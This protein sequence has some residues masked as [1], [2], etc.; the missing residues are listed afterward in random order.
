[1]PTNKYPITITPPI[2][3]TILE[4]E[5]KYD[6]VISGIPDADR[7]VNIIVVYGTA[8]ELIPYSYVAGGDNFLHIVNITQGTVLVIF[9]DPAGLWIESFY[10]DNAKLYPYERSKFAP[11]IP[12]Y[13]PLHNFLD[14][15][16]APATTI[17]LTDDRNYN[18]PFTTAELNLYERS[19]LDL[20][21]QPAYDGSINMIWTDDSN[22]MRIVNSRFAVDESGTIAELIDRRARKDANTYNNTNFHQTELI[23]KAVTIPTLTF[24]G[25]VPGGKLPGGGYRYFFKYV[26]ADGAETDI[27]EE[28]RLVSVHEGATTLTAMGSSTLTTN[29]SV[30]FTLTDLDQSFYGVVVYYTY[31]SGDVDSVAV[32][33]RIASPYIIENTG[34][35]TII[36]SG[37]ETQALEDISKL[38]LTYSIISRA[39][40]LDVVNN[41]LLVG[42]TDA[43]DIYDP[44][45][46][47]A[48]ASLLIEEDTF[49]IEQAAALDESLSTEAEN[50]YS[51]PLF[52]YNSL[53]YWKG[54]TYELGIV[55]VTAQGLSP[56]YTLQGIDN[57]AGGVAYDT[58]LIG[59]L[60]R[61]YAA[62]GQNSAGIYRT[63]QRTDLWTYDAGLSKLTFSGTNLSVDV[64]PL[65]TQDLADK[66]TGFFFVRRKRKSDVILQGLMVPVAAVPIE[67]RFGSEYEIT[68]FGNWAGVG[69]KSSV[70]K[71]NVKFIPAP[72]G[73]MPFGVEETSGGNTTYIPWMTP[74]GEQVTAIGGGPAAAQ[75]LTFVEGI[76]KDDVIR[77][78]SAGVAVPGT[79]LSVTSATSTVTFTAPITVAAGAQVMIARGG[80]SGIST[81]FY[82]R[83]PIKD[84]TDINSWAL[85]STDVECA[86]AYYA[87]ILSGTKVGLE[88]FKQ[89]FTTTQI[90]TT[91]PSA[92]L[93][94]NSSLYNKITQGLQPVVSA[95]G[96]IKSVTA[97]YVDTGAIG[98]SALG[99]SGSTDR[100][101]G[102]FMDW[103][104]GDS[105]LTKAYLVAKIQAASD[106]FSGTRAMGLS[107][108]SRPGNALAFGRYIGIKATE[109]LASSL[110][111]LTITP[112]PA[113]GDENI[114]AYISLNNLGQ[115]D[116][117]GVS[118]QLGYVSAL[119]PTST[120]SPIPL[121]AWE[122]RYAVDE[123]TEY[124][125]IT[126]RFRYSDFFDATGTPIAPTT[127]EIY[128]GDCFLGMSWK[129]VWHPL[130]IIEAPQTSDIT[131]Y[132]A[133]RRSLGLLPYGHAIPIPAQSNYNFNV[134]SKERVDEVE[135]K[136]YGTDRSYLPIRGINSIRGNRQFETG[137]YNHGYDSE[138]VSA[139]KQ[140]RLNL[141]APFYR[142]RYPNRIYVS[143]ES[144]ENEFV[145]GFS[146][147]KGLNFR[148][149]NSNLGAI[150]K[151]IALNNVLIVVFKDGVA[152]VGVDERSQVS[153]D[154]GG[155]FVDSA[156]ILSRSDVVNSDYGSDHLHSICAS[157]NFVY[158]VDF[159]RYKVWRTNGAAMELISD[160]KIRNKLG[161]ISETLLDIFSQNSTDRWVDVFSNF[162]SRKN[163]IYFTFIVRDPDNNILHNLTRT[164]VF[165]ETLQCWICETNDV[166]KFIFQSG[167]GRYALPSVVN[168]YNKIYKYQLINQANVDPT[169]EVFAEYNKFYDTIYDM[170]YDY[171]VIDDTSF[172]KIFNN[173][174]IIGNN[175]LPT[176]V[177]YTSDHNTLTEQVLQ[178][179]T[180]IRYP[181]I[182]TN[183]D[184]V[185]VN[186]V[187]GSQY[188]TIT[189][190]IAQIKAT[191]DSLRYGN[192]ISIQ[193][194]DA[195]T[196]YN[197]VVI[198]YVPGQ[199]IKV[200]KEVPVNFVNK[201]LYFGYG[202]NLPMRLTDSAFEESYGS[203][204]CQFNN[205]TAR[206]FSPTKLRG[207]WMRFRHTYEGTAPVYI[208]GI[209]TD[210]GIS[211]S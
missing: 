48:A 122:A 97:T 60:Y 147:F 46:A 152:K 91:N 159:T 211:L 23:P 134:R 86:P 43:T 205:R 40:T 15:I 208:S 9:Q 192:F 128:G 110:T 34:T 101:F 73:M 13:Q 193:G 72:N 200:D 179:Y 124:A 167:D 17:D 140:F 22:P 31:S 119:Y 71:G 126:K 113:V 171:H 37:Y 207:K 96:G 3:D 191:Q 74:S 30:K 21:L 8:I 85:Y 176:K 190:T 156:Q 139:F 61:G 155:V 42:N 28:S 172:Y 178:P 24:D 151:L 49:D 12:K 194:T 173:Q 106:Q 135:F 150:T 50:N 7:S 92:P 75:Q 11:L 182:D 41:R 148:D 16:V 35:C 158:G 54:E 210:Y 18:S 166:R 168:K 14:P 27:I 79:V 99:F 198:E 143:S 149:Y 65:G 137:R 44:D 69:V 5:I 45:L 90:N 70:A 58:D 87:S 201:Q 181:M 197:F 160:L 209:I 105:N 204:S 93:T 6:P 153:N 78:I 163:E 98:V 175:S 162:D 66:I 10:L 142:F 164:I 82:I 77:F 127:I 83:A 39:K 56:V 33:Y 53:G 2:A 184:P 169:V 195:H 52:I 80:G 187:A 26:T 25:L 114:N 202:S 84:Y 170:Y 63:E 109:D 108:G 59:G 19:V 20:K 203:I 185:I 177:Q 1:M 32:A 199:Y 68:G 120:G 196:K 4:L 123:D 141:N 131:A 146:N 102:L 161:S 55:Y 206:G 189:Q 129:Q 130:G 76:I 62:L 133:Q 103:I 57:L 188:L 111:A 183:D 116:G 145:N 67:T 136:V 118:S 107:I 38:S 180:N 165:N 117:L 186:A 36:H 154:T 138:G 174:F 94:G 88:C 81:D 125:A 29:M 95:L 157:N 144:S 121:S 47:V 132:K 51:N 115:L 104:V 100:N 64:D 112:T 89:A